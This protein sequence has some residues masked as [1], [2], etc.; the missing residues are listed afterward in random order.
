DDTVN[1][2]QESQV[3]TR[4]HM[5]PEEIVDINATSGGA[6]ASSGA[7][8]LTKPGASSDVWRRSRIL[9]RGSYGQ[10]P[11]SHHSVIYHK[12][13]SIPDPNYLIDYPD[14]GIGGVPLPNR[15]TIPSAR[16]LP[17]NM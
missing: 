11:F 8:P 5:A 14:I 10:G 6:I 2:H 12:I 15:S 13:N 3:G 9:Y 17:F 4:D 7:R 1:T 16:A